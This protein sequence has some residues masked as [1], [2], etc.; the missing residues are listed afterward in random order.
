MNIV[1]FVMD[2]RYIFIVLVVFS[3][4][5]VE[6]NEMVTFMKLLF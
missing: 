3:V 5:L 1:V 6:N 2:L 4:F